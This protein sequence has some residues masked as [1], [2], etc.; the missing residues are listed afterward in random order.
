MFLA[1]TAAAAAN[2]PDRGDF[3]ARESGDKRAGGAALRER[4]GRFG[5]VTAEPRTGTPRAVA[6][7]DGFLT[8]PSDRRGSDVVLD[9]VR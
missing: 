1:L 2:T 6:K 7:L 4:L 5:L 9:Y 8:G 3:D